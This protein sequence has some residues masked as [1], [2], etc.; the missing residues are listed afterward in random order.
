MVNEYFVVSSI[1][2]IWL[3]QVFTRLSMTPLN[4][5]DELDRALIDGF[6]AE[7]CEGNKLEGRWIHD[8]TFRVTQR[9]S[10]LVGCRV[11]TDMIRRRLLKLKYNFRDCYKNFDMLGG[12][13]HIAGFTWNSSTELI[14]AE[15]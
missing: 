1:C 11:G 2:C 5:N 4:W 8:V 12:F 3:K 7:H 10:A 13:Y 15:S 14:E 9:L 6:L